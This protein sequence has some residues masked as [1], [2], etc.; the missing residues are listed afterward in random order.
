MKWEEEHLLPQVVGMGIAATLM[1][2]L[3]SPGVSCDYCV[4][5]VLRERKP[6]VCGMGHPR[7]LLGA[8]S[9]VLRR[10]EIGTGKAFSV[11]DTC[12]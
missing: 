6:W 10:K 12:Y 1:S 7:F 11:F 8:W 9:L 4:E 2:I 5:A 3:C